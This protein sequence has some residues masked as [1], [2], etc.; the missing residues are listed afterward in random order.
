MVQKTASPV[1]NPSAISTN[2][3][4]SV[5]FAQLHAVLSTAKLS[6]LFFEFADFRPHDIHAMVQDRGNAGIN[7]SRMR[8][9]C[10][11]RSVKHDEEAFFTG[12]P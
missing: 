1:D 4:A 9:C 12:Q 3:S 11:A 10:A 2:C 6:K 7:F 5:P 8:A